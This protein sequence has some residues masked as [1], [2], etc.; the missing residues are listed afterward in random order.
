MPSVANYSPGR[1]S[2][3]EFEDAVILKELFQ[4]ARDK[5]KGRHFISEVTFSGSTHETGS[6]VDYGME[7]S[8]A[9]IPNPLH[10]LEQN[11]LAAAVI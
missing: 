6:H 7:S 8:S 4:N 11:F 3:S 5:P 2:F 9:L 1:R 10:V